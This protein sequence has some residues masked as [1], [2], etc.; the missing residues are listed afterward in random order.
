MQSAPKAEPMKRS[1]ASRP[2]PATRSTAI[3][4]Y[5]LPSPLRRRRRVTP[6]QPPAPRAESRQGP[7]PCPPLRQ[8]PH[9]G[10][11]RSQHAQRTDQR[12]RAL[13]NERPRQRQPVLRA[14]RAPLA[15][16]VV[17]EGLRYTGTA[18]ESQVEEPAEDEQEGD[19]LLAGG[20]RS[21]R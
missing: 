2:P 6:A 12:R 21:C 8:G 4:G 9:R 19:R 18:G 20:C 17:V 16:A 13:R 10:S 7:G 11:R 1:A 15:G 3:Q 5:D 14:E